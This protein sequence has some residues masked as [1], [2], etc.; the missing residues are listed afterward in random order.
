MGIGVEER[1][2]QGMTVRV[3][4]WE[5]TLVDA[6]DRL[7]LVGGWHEAWRSLETVEVYL[8]LDF[9]IE[10]AE[11]LNTAST[12]AKVGYFLEQHR[13]HFAVK[14]HHLNQLKAWRPLQPYYIE[15]SKKLSLRLS[16]SRCFVSGWNLWIPVE[17]SEY[18]ADFDE[19][20]QV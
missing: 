8:K 19:D 4:N 6:F 15:Q 9:L 2:R 16:N 1:H 11:W 18:G 12:C 5:R 13:E 10:Y 3:T 7:S 17:K 14:E 20:L